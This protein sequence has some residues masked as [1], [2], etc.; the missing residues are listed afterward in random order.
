V[1]L[2]ELSGLGR[3]GGEGTLEFHDLVLELV[4]NLLVVGGGTSLNLELLELLAGETPPE[5]RLDEDDGAEF[6]LVLSAAHPVWSRVN[7]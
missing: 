2:P 6:L 5:A 1:N 7:D 3:L 4:R